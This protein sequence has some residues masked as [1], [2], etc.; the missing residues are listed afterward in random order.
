[1]AMLNEEPGLADQLQQIK[2]AETDFRRNIC[3]EVTQLPSSA[4]IRTLS[5]EPLCFE[6]NKRCLA[7]DGSWSPGYYHFGLQ[8]KAVCSV[9][10]NAA[11]AITAI[12]KLWRIAATGTLSELDF[13]IHPVMRA[14]ISGIV[15][16]IDPGMEFQC[17]KKQEVHNDLQ[18]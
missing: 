5:E 16:K 8:K 3:A 7:G 13:R 2:K 14:H 17:E 15:S 12:R 4:D 11:N 1:M 9:I 10:T 6:I 18:L